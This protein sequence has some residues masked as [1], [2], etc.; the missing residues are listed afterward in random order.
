MLRNLA[1]DK[2]IL[3]VRGLPVPRSFKM[4]LLL[5]LIQEAMKTAHG[6]LIVFADVWKNFF[7]Q[8]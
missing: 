5:S 6:L 4:G 7:A 3:R 2:E 1:S 8:N